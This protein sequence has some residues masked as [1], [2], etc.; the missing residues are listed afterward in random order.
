MLRD[1]ERS[2]LGRGTFHLEK[3][4]T[5]VDG[6]YVHQGG[7]GWAHSPSPRLW[8]WGSWG[9]PYWTSRACTGSGY[10]GHVWGFVL[11]DGGS[12]SRIET[13][14]EVPRIKE[15]FDDNGSSIILSRTG[16]PTRLKSKKVEI[17]KEKMSQMIVK[18]KL[19][20]RAVVKEDGLR[21]V[22]LQ[23]RRLTPIGT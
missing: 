9:G 2:H 1:V 4:R 10:G 8:A 12:P 14:G 19:S 15:I 20:K 3:V 22:Y 13:H 23:E 5:V 21:W 16:F 6:R 18:E 11:W 7:G 17:G